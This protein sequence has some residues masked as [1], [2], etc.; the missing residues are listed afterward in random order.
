MGTSRGYRKDLETRVS[1]SKGYVGGSQ[2]PAGVT[3]F[4]CPRADSFG[5]RQGIIPPGV[6][7]MHGLI[8]RGLRK[9]TNAD[10][11]RRAVALLSDDSS[12][13][14]RYRDYYGSS[15][16]EP[17]APAVTEV[18]D[19]TVQEPDVPQ[20][21]LDDVPARRPVT[22]RSVGSV[23]APAPK[24][25]QTGGRQAGKVKRPV[26]PK[27]AEISDE[28]DGSRMFSEDDYE[29]QDED[30]LDAFYADLSGSGAGTAG[31]GGTR[32]KRGIR[33][34]ED[35]RDAAVEGPPPA[36]VSR[37]AE[38]ARRLAER[39]AELE[40]YVGRLRSELGSA[41]SRM[42]A[43][44]EELAGY[45]RALRHHGR[46][47][48]FLGAGQEKL[49]LGGRGWECRIEGHVD[50]GPVVDGRASELVLTVADPAYSSELLSV[51]PE[52]DVVLLSASG[53][54]YCT[55]SGICDKL[56]GDS[57]SHDFIACFRFAIRDDGDSGQGG[58]GHDGEAEQVD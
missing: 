19:E 18:P 56:Y 40:E 31:R 30:T 46:I 48:V 21:L 42:A 27:K 36:T 53:R 41:E 12:E 54:T 28:Y 11:G 23:K 58:Q 34:E 57:D 25:K 20:E 55:Y 10:V 44:E 24:K 3:G 4:V 45:R 35:A 2:L 47:R 33:P 9:V 16:G 5:G 32:E 37:T 13:S 1:D 26:S 52:G 6:A 39:C 49:K 29:I 7:A 15:S 17:Q 22:K 43:Y 38:H 8:P 50:L 14:D 51:M